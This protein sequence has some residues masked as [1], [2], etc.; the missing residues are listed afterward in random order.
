MATDDNRT[1]DQKPATEA[2]QK[3]LSSLAQTIRDY[4]KKR[5]WSDTQLC[6]RFGGVGSTKTFTRVLAGDLK[7][8]DLERWLL[9]YRTVVNL[10]E[11]EGA[12]DGNDEAIFDD[13]STCGRLRVA[14]LEI[15]N[16]RGNCRLIIVEGASGSGKT[17]AGR[18]LA[19]KYGRRVLFGEADETWKN[20][21]IMLGGILK[22]LGKK[23]FSG[24]TSERKE[25]VVAE[26]NLRRVCLFLDEAHH[27]GPASL[28]MLKTLIN[29]TPGE[30]ILS[31]L[32]TL[33]RRLETQAYYEALQLT[34]NR[35]AERINFDQLDAHDVEL[36]VKRRLG[37]ENGE[38][39]KAAAILLGN[40]G[41]GP[42]TRLGHLAFVDAVCRQAKRDAD[43]EP[44]TVELVGRAVTKVE[45]T[46]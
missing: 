23:E 31:G 3:E 35:M 45:K 46:R 25:L 8:L 13:L 9:E 14:F 11:A 34:R 19:A 10:I 15:M 43:G 6:K 32:G 27:L 37:W 4:Q 30:F 39:K 36:L 21:T 12:A 29:Q 38:G 18:M 44:V 22:M 33:L 16:V 42:A 41:K 24:G 20:P 28:N 1:E 17:K 5:G 2:Q 26:L 7:E 40:E